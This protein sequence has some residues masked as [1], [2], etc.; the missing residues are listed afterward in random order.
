MLV[1]TGTLRVDAT[2]SWCKQKPRKRLEHGIGANAASP[3]AQRS[4]VSVAS[5]KH[6]NNNN[7]KKKKKEHTE[8]AIDVASSA[9]DC[10]NR[11]QKAALS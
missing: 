10:R 2:Y 4:K 5:L 3:I 7:K 1:L 9:H 6:P 8:L 11:E